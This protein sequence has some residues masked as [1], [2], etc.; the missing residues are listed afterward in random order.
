MTAGARAIGAY[1]I[2]IALLAATALGFNAYR[3]ALSGVLV[4]FFSYFTI[5]SNLLGVVVFLVG[6]FSALTGRRPVPDLLRG[7]AALYLVVTG[8]VYAVAL[9]QYD[10]PQ[11]IPWV[12]DVVHRVT[13]LLFAA[14][15]LIDPPR[16]PLAFPRALAWLVFPLLYLLYTL[17]RG[18]IVGW[19]PYP[20]LDPRE[21]GYLHVAVGGIIVTAAFLAAA[22]LLCWAGTLLYA[23]RLRATT[24][25]VKPAH[26]QR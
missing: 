5:E 13:P 15:W 8:V 21:H 10:T 1:R 4:N 26:S 23:R 9:A 2:A 16:R 3:S 20:F 18:P 25:A 7:A 22:A 17:V 24:T 6:G 14:D 11:V 12:N 19:Y